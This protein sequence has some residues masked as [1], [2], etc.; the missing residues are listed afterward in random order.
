MNI[1][2]N[3]EALVVQ[4]IQPM[5]STFPN[6]DGPAATADWARSPQA[7]LYNLRQMAFSD[8]R[9]PTLPTPN[10]DNLPFVYP[11]NNYSWRGI[12]SESRVADKYFAT[13]NQPPAGQNQFN[14]WFPTNV[15]LLF[16]GHNGE[17]SWILPSVSGVPP[18][19]SYFGT[20]PIY[21]SSQ[22][23]TGN[24]QRI[25]PQLP[26]TPNY[27]QIG[28]IGQMSYWYFQPAPARVN[29][30]DGS[31]PPF[32]LNEMIAERQRAIWTIPSSGFVGS[33]DL[34]VFHVEQVQPFSTDPYARARF[35]YRPIDTF[36]F[37]DGIA[38]TN[39]RLVTPHFD[40]PARTW[41]ETPLPE[42]AAATP[43]DPSSQTNYPGS[44]A[45]GWC[46]KVYFSVFFETP[47]EWQARTGVTFVT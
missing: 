22:R 2:H 14:I 9:G 5:L 34:I 38:A 24:E 40:L 29:A 21:V 25:F 8:I 31:N 47:A 6:W 17:F 39:F 7:A 32:W 26:A 23:V 37:Y 18:E 41:W 13:D 30:P 19:S 28:D 16:Q 3:G 4:E 1:D 35:G 12:S 15:P 43:G 27:E 11:R 46:G 10:P 45:S 20:D 44:P 42:M 36:G 33:A